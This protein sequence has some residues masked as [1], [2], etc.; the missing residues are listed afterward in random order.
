MTRLRTLLL[1]LL[2]PALLMPD[3]ISLCMRRLLG[4]PATR[5]CCSPCC[6]HARAPKSGTTLDSSDGHD[7]CVA[8]PA[9]D[10]AVER[11]AK[12]LSEESLA[13]PIVATLPPSF[14]VAPRLDALALAPGSFHDPP[15]FVVRISL[16][17]RL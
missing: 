14:A 8:M 9:S 1:A 4:E 7:C 5:S 11:A 2:F 10:R 13:A 16:P 12:K 15:R 17:L 3:G 6:R